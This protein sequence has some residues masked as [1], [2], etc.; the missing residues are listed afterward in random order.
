MR[1]KSF[2]F[3]TST[4]QLPQKPLTW[5][6]GIR[7]LQEV[8]PAEPIQL[9]VLLDKE[10]QKVIFSEIF[11]QMPGSRKLLRLIESIME[12]G[13][14]K[15]E[16]TPYRPLMIEFEQEKFYKEMAPP[17]EKIG[18]AAQYLPQP[19]LI[20]AFAE[21]ALDVFFQTNDDMDLLNSPG[22]TPAL[23]GEFFKAAAS[24]FHQAPWDYLSETQPLQLNTQPG[25]ECYY[26]FVLQGPDDE[27][28]ILFFTHWEDVLAFTTGEENPFE[29]I[30]QNRVL[31]VHY[32]TQENVTTGD[33]QAIQ[34]YGWELPKEKLFPNP[35]S[36]AQDQLFRPNG[37]QLQFQTAAL[38]AIT[39]FV[40]Q[41]LRPSED[42]DYLPAQAIYEIET[43]LGAIEVEVHYPVPHILNIKNNQDFGLEDANQP[44]IQESLK[45]ADQAWHA[46]DSEQRI[47]LAQQALA[48]WQDCFVAHT[49]LGEEADELEQALEYFQLGVAAAE[50]VLDFDMFKQHTGSIW[51]IHLGKHYLIAMQGVVESLVGLEAYPEAVPLAKKLLKMNPNDHQGIR[52]ILL[53]VL[54]RLQRDNETREL[55]DLYPMENAASWPYSRA[56]IEF[57][58]K[59]ENR[60]ARLLLQ[61]AFECN[62]FIP[63]YLT[64]KKPIPAELPEF[65]SFGDE[66]EAMNYAHDYY[67][68]W[69]QS[70]GAIDW[71]KRNL[72]AWHQGS[73]KS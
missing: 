22:V 48:A 29:S 26:A 13:D 47:H 15:L 69:W 46:E 54:T 66:P 62:P 23:A 9:L 64:G 30:A 37:T 60:K 18:I 39:R 7:S 25:A 52:Y 42:Q 58:Q 20:D 68:A 32:E 65:D 27:H 71:L 67:T 51:E 38:Q 4:F 1:K 2:Q 28:L 10:N 44:Y 45:L 63:D 43:S 16:V 59:G 56:L 31:A 19:N 14:A 3:K 8:L 41:E 70:K 12:S 5:Y 53:V 33:L 24:C 36:Y 11:S 73:S 40:S 72:Q 61:E 55:L 49:I 35:Y 50:R 34:R 6:L 21:Q 17:M 57:R